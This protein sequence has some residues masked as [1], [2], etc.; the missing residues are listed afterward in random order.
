MPRIPRSE[1]TL[2]AQQVAAQVHRVSVSPDDDGN[3]IEQRQK[4]K[5]DEV[6]DWAEFPEENR[7]VV[8]TTAGEK[9]TGELPAKKADAGAKK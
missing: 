6:F 9:L 7:L 1:S 4:V 2:T 3:P 5:A 8:V